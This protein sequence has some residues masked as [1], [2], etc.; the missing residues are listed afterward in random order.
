MKGQKFYSVDTDRTGNTRD[1]LPKRMTSDDFKEPQPVEEPEEWNGFPCPR[2]Y[3]GERKFYEPKCEEIDKAKETYFELPNQGPSV[4]RCLSEGV[5][6]ITYSG[7]MLLLEKMADVL[8]ENAKYI[9]LRLKALES[10]V[11]WYSLTT[12]LPS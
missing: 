12:V 8:D 4:K 7:K 2:L 5:G 9:D 6:P 1:D 10:N 3:P 11:E